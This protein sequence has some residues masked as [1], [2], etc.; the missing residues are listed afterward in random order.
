LSPAEEYQLGVQ[1][2]AEVT[3]EARQKNALITSGPQVD[4]V[5]RVGHKIAEVATSNSQMSELLRKEINIHID[6]FRYDWEFA[7]IRSNQVNAFC[8]PAGKVAV[9]TGL[10]D[11]IAHDGSRDRFRDDW[12]ATVLGHEIAHALAHHASERLARQQLTGRAIGMITHGF[13]SAGTGEKDSVIHAIA[14]FGSLPFARGQESEADHV[15]VFLMTFAGYDPHAAVEFWQAMSQRSGGGRM[16]EILS[17]HPSDAR[18][19]AQLKA[20]ADQA[21]AARQA[22]EAGKTVDRQR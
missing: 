12:L 2:F 6:G 20:W 7:V 17:D 3:G 11:L 14:G 9:F 15:G 1:A 8:L 21:A 13:G 18:R 5:R 19:V 10:L 16:P 4:V 22:Y